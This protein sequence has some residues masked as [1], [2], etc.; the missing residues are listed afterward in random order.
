METS[1]K[2]K[3]TRLECFPLRRMND[4]T[5]EV[6][7]ISWCM[8]AVPELVGIKCYFNVRICMH[9]YAFRFVKAQ[10]D[11]IYSLAQQT[12]FIKIQSENF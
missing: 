6:F 1:K 12:C 5:K 4:G 7:N 8:L 11:G 10:E 3:I 2:K 9:A